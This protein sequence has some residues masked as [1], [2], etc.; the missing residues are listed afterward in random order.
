MKR[1]TATGKNRKFV[2]IIFVCACRVLY[3]MLSY[4]RRLP[5]AEDKQKEFV[6]GLK[7]TH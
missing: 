2:V 6:Y 4:G 5:M 1:N 3:K 7:I